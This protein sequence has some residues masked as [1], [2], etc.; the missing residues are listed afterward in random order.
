MIGNWAA[1]FAQSEFAQTTLHSVRRR[2][3]PEYSHR[4]AAAH[5]GALCCRQSVYARQAACHVANVVRIV[6]YREDCRT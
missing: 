3:K 4:I 6:G 1:T 5:G 2:S